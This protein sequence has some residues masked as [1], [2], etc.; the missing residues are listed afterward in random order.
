MP[1]AWHYIRR[2]SNYLTLS[3]VAKSPFYAGQGPIV[4]GQWTVKGVVQGRPLGHPSHLMFVHFPSALFPT[5]VIFDLISPFEPNLALTRA[6]FYNVSVGLSVGIL[7]ALTG[8]VDYLPMISGSRKKQV[9]TYHLVSQVI[10]MTLLSASFV[11]RALDFD[12]YRI[13]VLALAFAIV[14]LAALSIGNWFGGHLVDR[15]GMR[16]N[17]G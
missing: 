17:T 10:M 4:A 8:L 13:P 1:A 6:A 2:W 14:G 12:A 9:G 16:V 7:A 3:A 5:A 15:Q 11:V